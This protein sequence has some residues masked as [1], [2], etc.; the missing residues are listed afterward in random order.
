MQRGEI[1]RL[2]FGIP[3]DSVQ[4]GVRPGLIIQSDALVMQNDIGNRTSSTTIVAAI[5]SKRKKS[6]PFHVEISKEE[7]GLPEDSTILLEQIQTV[8]QS[9]LT[10][11]KGELDKHKM[12]EV[13]GALICSLG[14]SLP[15]I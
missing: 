2:D 12:E 9:R 6:Y 5:T 13:D 11:K 1:Y 7:S 14:I 4:A 15:K 3:E 8:P 10:E